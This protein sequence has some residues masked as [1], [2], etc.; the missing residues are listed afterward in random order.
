MPNCRQRSE[1]DFRGIMEMCDRGTSLIQE[2]VKEGFLEV[3]TL[4]LKPEEHLAV[5]WAEERGWR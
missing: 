3:G 1:G 5:N 2:V 4:E